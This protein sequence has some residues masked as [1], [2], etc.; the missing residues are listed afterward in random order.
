MLSRATPNIPTHHIRR[1][2]RALFDDEGD[3][4][5]LAELWNSPS[6]LSRTL[7]EPVALHPRAAG[8]VP[9]YCR[10]GTTDAQVFDD[11]FVGLYH[12]PPIGLARDAVILDLGANVGYTAAHY[13]AML[14]EA[15]IVCVEMDEQNAALAR[16]N[17]AAF[18]ARCMVIRAAAWDVDGEVAY[19]GEEEWGFRVGALDGVEVRAAGRKVAPAL[20]VETIM[21]R[22]GVSA[23][24]FAKIDVEGAEAS[25]VRPDSAWLRRVRSIKVEHHPP[26]TGETMTRALVGAGFEVRRDEKHPRGVVGVRAD[27]RA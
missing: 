12:L 15:R 5:R 6:P 14:P 17:L 27:E 13:A 19:G 9:L 16:R 1:S 25:I 26:A 21:H 10:P 11:T 22:A 3:A 2:W 7:G 8:S 23:I 4:A 18:G 20:T 24:D